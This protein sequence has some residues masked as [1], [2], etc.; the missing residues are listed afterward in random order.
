VPKIDIA[1]AEDIKNARARIARHLERLV[2]GEP[3]WWVRQADSL[4]S[5]WREVAIPSLTLSVHG[6]GRCSMNSIDARFIP[7]N[8][9]GPP[10]ICFEPHYANL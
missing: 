3:A 9:A 5:N 4:N 2:L 7:T 10:M 6:L 1:I 8:H